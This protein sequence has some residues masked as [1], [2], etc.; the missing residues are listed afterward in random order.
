M[1]RPF[2]PFATRLSH[3]NVPGRDRSAQ[4]GSDKNSTDQSTLDEPKPEDGVES[5]HTYY[6]R[7]PN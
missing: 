4:G 2:A 3:R 7:H 6:K 5:Q 1:N